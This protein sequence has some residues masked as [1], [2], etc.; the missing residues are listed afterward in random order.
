MRKIVSF[1]KEKADFERIAGTLANI[2]GEGIEFV[3]LSF[4]KIAGI[5]P[6]YPI[7]GN[8]NLPTGILFEVKSLGIKNR[9]TKK[10]RHEYEIIPL[11][12]DFKTSEI[13]RMKSIVNNYSEGRIF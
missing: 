3:P 7:V 1:R 6:R 10:E 5:N 13:Y 4:S 8:E 11:Q 9:Y 2:L 12:V